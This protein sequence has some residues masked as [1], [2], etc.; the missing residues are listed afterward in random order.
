MPLP[1]RGA[2]QLSEEGVVME[3]ENDVVDQWGDSCDCSSPLPR[4]T[5]VLSL[6]AV[7]AS[8]C[9]GPTM[10]ASAK[11]ERELLNEAANLSQRISVN[12]IAHAGPLAGT[13]AHPGYS[14]EVDDVLSDMRHGRLD[15][16]VFSTITD[17]LLRVAA[18]PGRSRQYRVPEPGELFRYAQSQLG[19]LMKDGNLAIAL[20]PAD[21]IAYK[22]RGV[23]CAV[24]AFEGSDPLEGN[25][26]HVPLFY[27]RGLR[28]LQ[29]VHFRINELGDVQ[30]EPPRHGGLTLFGRDVVREMN[31]LGMV[32]DIAH[33]HAETARGVLAESRHPI[34]DSHTRPA[35]RGTS[36]RFRSDDEL[37][38]V[39]RK[40][41]VVGM[42][43]SAR[44]KTF[45]DF[46]SDVDYVKSIIGIDHVGIGTDLNGMGAETVVPTH[47]EFALI[48]AGLLARGYSEGEVAKVVGGNFL[49]VFREV[50][51]NR[52]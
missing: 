43:P 33:A 17:R 9:S 11:R 50:T 40:G 51:E 2:A 20:S 44:G 31:R 28:V 13:A 19:Q 47:K 15:A 16:A 48:P 14:R 23:P 25:L 38:A 27:D 12:L 37:R 46:L 4:R 21:L 36:P 35:A 32:V 1:C 5:F 29:L 10:S 18:Q 52:G 30:T 3:E 49:R 45:D 39:A 34:I 6:L 42:Q 26:S 8:A 7:I 24:L 41:G 22:N